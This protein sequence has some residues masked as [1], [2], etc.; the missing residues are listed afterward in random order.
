MTGMKLKLESLDHDVLKNQ[1]KLGENV[2]L[3]GYSKMQLFFRHILYLLW[4]SKHTDFKKCLLLGR[5]DKPRQHIKK[6]RRSI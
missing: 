3:N 5:N 4:I 2:F 6:Q 1:N